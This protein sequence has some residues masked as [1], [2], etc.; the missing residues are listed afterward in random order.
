VRR[1]DSTSESSA[2]TR[3]RHAHRYA[4]VDAASLAPYWR[5]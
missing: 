2:G 4:S 5:S 1:D 3:H